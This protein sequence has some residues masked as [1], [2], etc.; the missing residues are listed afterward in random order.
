MRPRGPIRHIR[1]ARLPALRQHLP[2]PLAPAQHRG[3]GHLEPLRTRPNRATGMNMEPSQFQP[4]QRGQRGITVGHEGLLERCDCL[5]A[6][7]LTREAFT[8]QEPKP[9]Y[10]P[11]WVEHL[12]L[13]DDVGQAP[14][15]HSSHPH[16]IR[17]KNERTMPK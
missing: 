6:S 4:A 9:R 1:H 11:L 12:D 14:Q 5:V 3:R 15:E 8:R 7:H 13:D 2:I 10:Q 17:V 16:H